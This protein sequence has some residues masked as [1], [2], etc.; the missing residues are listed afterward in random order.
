MEEAVRASLGR[1]P[2]IE[3][4]VAAPE[5]KRSPRKGKVRLEI[6]SQ[7]S[8]FRA[9]IAR[10]VSDKLD[11]LT[12]RRAAP[13]V[14]PDVLPKSKVRDAGTGQGKLPRPPGRALRP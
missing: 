3:F 13:G 1:T 14:D 11:L 10:N 4:G 2:F 7:R 6:G 8:A 9:R 5:S 12:V